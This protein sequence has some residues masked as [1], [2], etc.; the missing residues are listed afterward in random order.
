M[1]DELI[2]LRATERLVAIII[3]GMAI[4]F[5]YRLFLAVPD[6]AAD[7]RAELTLAKNQRLLITRIGPGTFFALFGSAVVMASLLSAVSLQT[8]QGDSY[9]A[10]GQRQ[11]LE[12]ESASVKSLPPIPSINVADMMLSLAF[13]NELELELAGAGTEHQRRWREQ[14]FRVARLAIL[15]RGW[16]HSWGDFAEFELWLKQDPPRNVRPEFERVLLMMDGRE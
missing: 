1:L 2:M 10:A 5:G 3:G 12:A 14:R 16:Q 6:Q 15:G 8:G 4:W 7:G 9:S 11:L 13:L